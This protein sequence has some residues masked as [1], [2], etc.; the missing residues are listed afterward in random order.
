MSKR[1][2]VQRHP[3]VVGQ[4]VN[5]TWVLLEPNKKH[6]RQLN[7]TAGAIWE[8]TESPVSAEEVTDYLVARYP[9]KRAAVAQDVETFLAQYVREGLLIK[10]D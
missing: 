4:K 1:A 7:M 10:V 8:C 2:K 9:Q 3:D 5:D 6:V